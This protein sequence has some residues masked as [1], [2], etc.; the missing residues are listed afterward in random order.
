M[1]YLCCRFQCQNY[2]EVS[3]RIW[4][5]WRVLGI[6]GSYSISHI[7]SESLICFVPVIVALVYDKCSM[8]VSVIAIWIRYH[9]ASVKMQWHG[10]ASQVYSTHS[11]I[12]PLS[13]MIFAIQMLIVMLCVIYKIYNCILLYCK[14][15]KINLLMH[16]S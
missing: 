5:N 7:L 1:A 15:D 11:C 6:K 10:S 3:I 14:M 2:Y 4:Y 13:R 16:I 12:D 9:V 8:L